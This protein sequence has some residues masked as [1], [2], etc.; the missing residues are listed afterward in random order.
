[1]CVCVCV[2]VCV[3]ACVFSEWAVMKS[4]LASPSSKSGC[5]V[6]GDEVNPIDSEEPMRVDV[7]TNESGT[8]DV[9]S[10][11]EDVGVSSKKEGVR[12]PTP[13]PTPVS[14]ASPSPLLHSTTK[15]ALPKPVAESL[16]EGQSEIADTPSLNTNSVTPPTA[17]I[18]QPQ[19]LPSTDK[20]ATH[21]L[22]D[23]PMP[24]ST[25]P[26][27]LPFMAQTPSTSSSVVMEDSDNSGMVE[28]LAPP[29]EFLLEAHRHLGR[30]GWCCKQSGAFLKHSVSALRKE[31]D[32]LTKLPEKQR[33]VRC[34]L[35]LLERS[36]VVCCC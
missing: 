13:L 34:C 26:S 30:M 35:L 20:P 24:V 2:C 15:M 10:E 1:M 19:T 16:G 18:T 25:T 4:E 6:E 27:P 23:N 17:M 29:L 11:L 28:E 12:P 8:N 31:L 32:I 14:S 22:T 36:G 21:P 33:E 3:C 7:V 5:V 9:T